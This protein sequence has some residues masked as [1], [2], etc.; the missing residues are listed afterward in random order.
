MATIDK[1]IC[2][3]KDEVSKWF[4][5]KGEVDE[6]VNSKADNSLVTGSSNGL[7][8]SSDK[9]KLDGVATGANKTTV[10]SAMSSTSVNPVQNK[11]VKTEL[12]S[13]N[14]TKANASH[15]HSRLVPTDIPANSDLNDYTT[16]GSFYCPLNA[17]AA[18]VGNTPSN[19]AFHLEVYKTTGSSSKGVCQVAYSFHQDDVHSWWRNGYGGNW[20]E[21]YEV[22]NKEDIASLNNNKAN[23]NHT[24]NDNSGLTQLTCSYGN[25][26]KFKK[27]GWVTVIWGNLNTSGMATNSWVTLA[28]TGWSNQ[29][30]AHNYYG[31]F[32]QG[33]S[34][35]CRVTV[36]PEGVLRCFKPSSSAKEITYGY[37]IYPTED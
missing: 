29:A 13:L 6:K 7:M 21:W 14:T 30:P 25:V 18:T 4:Y 33:D 12:D 15:V 35:T 17:T 24:H 37:I 9:I 36:N 26:W 8:S 2:N 28:S 20:S 10:D 19:Q 5:Q 3:L 31:N 23:S 34:D 11:V 1:L 16:Q 27:N 22:A 32:V